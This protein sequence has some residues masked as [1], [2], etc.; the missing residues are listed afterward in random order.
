MPPLR[1]LAMTAPSP[2]QWWDFASKAT[3]VLAIPFAG[4]AVK[5]YRRWRK[6][7]E[8]RTLE[9]KAVRYILDAMRH[10]LF[11][12][13]ANERHLY[14]LDEL[15]RQKLLIDQLRDDLWIAD[16]HSLERANQER[17][18]EIVSVITRT[19]AIAAKQ[20]AYRAGQPPMFK[21]PS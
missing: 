15:Q 4:G 8:V 10:S 12:L 17:M 16:G 1:Q 18:A 13:T 20:E 9:A 14:S 7:R 21:D 5:A 11:A 3:L 2:E 6:R 19:Q